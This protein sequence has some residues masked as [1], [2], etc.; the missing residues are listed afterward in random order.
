MSRKKKITSKIKTKN[1]K[2]S[3]R[4]NIYMSTGYVESLPKKQ[5]KKKREVEREVTSKEKRKKM[6]KS[7]MDKPMCNYTWAFLSKNNVQ[8]FP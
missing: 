7:N 5:E 8:F 4:K 6:K 3:K 2:E 1:T